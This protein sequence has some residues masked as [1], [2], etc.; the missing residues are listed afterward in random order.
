METPGWIA[1]GLYIA[2]WLFAFCI[3]AYMAGKCGG[4][5]EDRLVF[6]AALVC[7]GWPLLALWSAFVLTGEARQP[8]PPDTGD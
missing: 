4:G 3:C 1:V 2:G 6:V 5:D 7:L 8:T